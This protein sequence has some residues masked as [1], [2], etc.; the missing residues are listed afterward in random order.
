MR[1]IRGTN[2]SFEATFVDPDG[3]PLVPADETK[4][5][6][7]QIR[8]PY[9]T[10]V[11]AGVGLPIGGGVYRF[12]W[13]VPV[14]AIIN[15]D[16]AR[17]VIDWHLSTHNGFNKS[18]SEKFDVIDKVEATPEDRQ[19]TLLTKQ[20]R[21]E[22][23]SIQR[24]CRP[25]EIGYEVLYMAASTVM[26]KFGPEPDVTEGNLASDDLKPTNP[27]RKIGRMVQDGQFYYY[28][29]TD[30]LT[31]PGKYVVFWNLRESVPS[32]LETYQRNIEVPPDRYWL[33]N[34]S[35]RKLIDKLQKRIGQLQSYSESDIYEYITQ[36]LGYVNMT[37]PYTQWT[38]EQV[39]YTPGNAIET[40]ILLGAALW[41]LNAQQIL[42]VE[43]SFS[44]GGQTVTLEYNH[45]Y[46]GI[47]SNMAEMF[48]KFA[49]ETKKQIF[50]QACGPA[51]VGVRP[52][53]YGYHNRVWRVG[54][55][56]GAGPYDTQTLL[57]QVGL[58]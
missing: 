36:G 28:F 21:Q 39:P 31:V 46:G 10:P 37:Y 26:Q 17:W 35:L 29:D 22:R 6:S 44:H 18:H 34:M 43:L 9:G 30:P 56:G 38:L 16:E 3:E 52:K 12:T 13:F 40:A 4:P 49:E 11:Q 5:T 57:S 45:D 8:D 24:S 54:N 42:E 55:W 15:T 32:A 50:R 1:F 48:G 53:N 51:R 25:C 14:D 7:V 58:Y 23:V 20:G 2:V 19:W 33:I 27:Q 47:I 41:G